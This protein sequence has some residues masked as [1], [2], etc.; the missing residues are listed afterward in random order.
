MADPLSTYLHDHLAGAEFGINLIRD[1]QADNAENLLGAFAA[2]LLREIEDDR[3]VLERLAERTGSTTSP[4]KDAAGWVGE[5][6]SRM[7]L[8][9]A[10]GDSGTFQ[11]LEALSIGILGKLK[12][13]KALEVSGDPRM[14]GPDFGELAARAEDQHNRVEERRLAF[15]RAAFHPRQS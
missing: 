7:K 11:Q 12:L 1:I 9:R 15:A 14:A 13:W 6:A 5:K 3:K 2:E 8:N 4:L 10:S